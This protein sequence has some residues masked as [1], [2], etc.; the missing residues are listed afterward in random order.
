MSSGG[1]SGARRAD[2]GGGVFIGVSLFS[3]LQKV[4]AL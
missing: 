1:D 2:G 4:S 3:T